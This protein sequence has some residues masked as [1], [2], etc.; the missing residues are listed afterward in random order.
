MQQTAVGEYDHHD[1]DNY[2]DFMDS[3]EVIDYDT[4]NTDNK[5]IMVNDKNNYEIKSNTC[6]YFA[7]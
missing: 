7:F 1:I 2:I 3:L 6:W 5:L 4:Q